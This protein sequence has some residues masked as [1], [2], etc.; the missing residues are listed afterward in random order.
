MTDDE[1][2]VHVIESPHDHRPETAALRPIKDLRKW[3]ETDHTVCTIS[4][5]HTHEQS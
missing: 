1:L 2:R 4:A 3:H 5:N